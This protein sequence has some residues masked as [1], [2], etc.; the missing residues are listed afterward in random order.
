[1]IMSKIAMKRFRFN[2]DPKTPLEDLL[3]K[4]PKDRASSARP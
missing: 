1:M 2:I 4:A 3:P